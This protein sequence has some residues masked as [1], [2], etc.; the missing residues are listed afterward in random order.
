ML[1]RHVLQLILIGNVAADEGDMPRRTAEHGDQVRVW[2][3]EIVG[4]DRF[5]ASGESPNDV[6]WD[7]AVATRNERCHEQFQLSRTRDVAM[8]AII[9]VS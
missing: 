6:T 7:P 8:P 1:M 3:H 5:T 9:T 4:D 2:L